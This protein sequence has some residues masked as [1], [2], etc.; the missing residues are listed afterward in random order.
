MSGYGLCLPGTIVELPYWQDSC[1]AA[2]SRDRIEL[3][4]GSCRDVDV[5]Y[6]SL[7]LGLVLFGPAARQ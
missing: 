1:G 6:A 7:N 3:V 5:F 4:A 2:L